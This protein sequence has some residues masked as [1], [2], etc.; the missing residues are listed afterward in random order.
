MNLI[1]QFAILFLFLIIGILGACAH[2]FK[3]RYG[4]KTIDCSLLAYIKGN[5]PATLKAI[6][7]LF[8]AEFAIAVTHIVSNSEFSLQEIGLAW[9]AGYMLDS[10]FNRP[11][12]ADKT[13]R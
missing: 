3:K 13:G 10:W 9:T 11:S 7:A 4:D 6:Y 5:R 2:Y 12:E 8:A 1:T